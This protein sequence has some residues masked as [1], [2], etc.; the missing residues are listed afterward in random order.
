MSIVHLRSFP[1]KGAVS[2][3]NMHSFEIY[4]PAAGTYY[5]SLSG[6]AVLSLLGFGTILLQA[7]GASVTP[8]ITL[9]DWERINNS[10]SSLAA[11]PWKAFPTVADQD[12]KDLTPYFG[13]AIKLVFSGP[14]R[15]IISVI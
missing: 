9:D 3:K 15:A 7:S 4:V 14:G 10:P 5:A 2:R 6:V 1:R 13:S 8:S 12:I 11:A